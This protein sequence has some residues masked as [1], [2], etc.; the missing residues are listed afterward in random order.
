LYSETAADFAYENVVSQTEFALAQKALNAID[1]EEAIRER[2]ELMDKESKAESEMSS[3]FTS[4]T[5]LLQP[6]VR[7]TTP[8]D[9]FAT[10]MEQRAK[11]PEFAVDF[12]YVE[13]W[14][15][16]LV[17]RDHPE[18]FRPTEGGIPP[19]QEPVHAFLAE[20]RAAELNIV[21]ILP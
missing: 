16:F 6:L 13:R 8:P 3:K 4:G 2:I 5:I 1:T 14:S 9:T 20:M 12:D 10:A 11:T 21:E 7:S 15:G 18:L 19:T 17:Q